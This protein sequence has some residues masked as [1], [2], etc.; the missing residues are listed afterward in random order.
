MGRVTFEGYTKIIAIL[1]NA[2]LVKKDDSH[3][4]HW[5]AN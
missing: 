5:I 3:L 2:G 1:V 4:L